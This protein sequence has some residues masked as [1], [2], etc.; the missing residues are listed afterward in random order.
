MNSRAFM[1]HLANTIPMLTMFLRSIFDRNLSGV[2][3][4]VVLIDML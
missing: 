3:C 4:A 2:W 1:R